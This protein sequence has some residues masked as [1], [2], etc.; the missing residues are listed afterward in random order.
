MT[1]EPQSIGELW[2][3]IERDSDNTR[4]RVNLTYGQIKQELNDV[5]KRLDGFVTRD[6]FEAE[7]RLLQQRVD[8]LEEAVKKL[9]EEA[10][11]EERSR[12]QGRRDFLYKG[13][14]P[15]ISLIIAA[16]SLFAVF[17]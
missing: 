16:I 6:H 17:H 2:R 12:Q 13:I 4:E 10:S 7:K 1:T 11:E 8:H 5:K 3:L 9:E 15:G 14:I